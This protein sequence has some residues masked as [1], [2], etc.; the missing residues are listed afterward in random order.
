MEKVLTIA[1]ACYNVEA[2]LEKGLES[3]AD[4]RLEEGLEVL[5]ISDGS[6]DRTEELAE[7]YTEKYP[8]IFRLIKKP[9]GGHGSV[10]NVAIREA[11]GIYFRMLDGDDWVMTEPLV[12]LISYLKRPHGDIVCD[13]KAEVHMISGKKTII[14]L[15][16]FDRQKVPT[17]SP[18]VYPF[19]EICA[20][21]EVSSYF[22]IHNFQVRTQLLKDHQVQVCEH[23]FYEDSEYVL[24]ATAYA[25]TVSFVDLEIYQ[26]LVGNVNQSVSTANFVKRYSHFDQVTKQ[27]LAFQKQFMEYESND[28]VKYYVLMRARN[29]VLTQLYIALIY[30][31]DRKRGKERAKVFFQFLKN[32]Y[33]DMAKLVAGR[34][35]LDCVLHG[36]GFNYEK[37]QKL[38]H[39]A[40]KK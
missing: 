19:E 10:I 24:K 16:G 39:L 5:I 8:K 3:L 17:M 37:F 11:S 7:R 28:M 9:N 31:E 32:E 4:P 34:Y 23:V 18:G 38:R 14:P 35:R 30:D 27:M 25:K 1:M 22:M 36:L 33:P 29:V 13:Y 20:L 26:Y 6:T 21:P 40:G 12:A 15:P 2:Y